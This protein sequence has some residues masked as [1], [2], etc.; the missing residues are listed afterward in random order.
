METRY[1]QYQYHHNLAEDPL[2]VYMSIFIIRFL[3]L[4]LTIRSIDFRFLTNQK[5]F[6]GIMNHFF[7]KAIMNCLTILNIQPGSNF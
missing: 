3:S 6:G 1:G 5:T 4:L 7:I 2:T